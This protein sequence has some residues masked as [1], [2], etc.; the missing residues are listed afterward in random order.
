MTQRVL[1]IGLKSEQN[2]RLRG[3]YNSIDF[4]FMDSNDKYTKV[5]NVSKYD[6]IYAL[7]K[8]INHSI[9]NTGRNHPGYVM[10]NGGMSSL[11]SVLDKDLRQ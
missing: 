4:N 9:H 5:K 8:F 11:R 6:K 7:V 10:I 2:Q 3:I 1:V